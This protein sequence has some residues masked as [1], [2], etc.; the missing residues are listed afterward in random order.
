MSGKISLQRLAILLAVAIF[1][2]AVIL[3]SSA[4]SVAVTSAIPELLPSA[5][6]QSSDVFQNEPTPEK[7]AALNEAQQRR[8]DKLALDERKS[9]YMERN[10]VSMAVLF[11]TFLVFIVGC[12]LLY[13]YAKNH[14]KGES[15]VAEPVS[16]VRTD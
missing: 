7:E 13:R 15:T 4:F 12:I 3:Y 10:P 11:E 9:L 2:H 14:H 6:A 8:L 16:T 5:L 1:G